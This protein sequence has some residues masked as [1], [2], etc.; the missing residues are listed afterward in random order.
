MGHKSVYLVVVGYFDPMVFAL[1]LAHAQLARKGGD[2]RFWSVAAWRKELVFDSQL[3]LDG[4]NIPCAELGNHCLDCLVFVPYV[5][6][7]EFLNVLCVDGR[8]NGFDC[9]QVDNLL[10][11]VL[12]PLYLLVRLE[13]EEI[14]TLGV[15]LNYLVEE[16]WFIDPLAVQV[17]VP[18]GR[19]HFGLAEDN[20]E[21]P[22]L[23]TPFGCR[24]MARECW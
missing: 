7:L 14:S 9:H 4:D 18:G 16:L 23:P 19:Y 17:A 10:E 11:D 20:W 5:V 2:M 12:P 3:L 13:L 1:Y 15:V 8:D 21:E 24:K 6:L 22:M